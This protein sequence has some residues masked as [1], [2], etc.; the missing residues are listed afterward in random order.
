MPLKHRST[1]AVLTLAAALLASA[2]LLGACGGGDAAEGGSDVA[3]SQ[4]EPAANAASTTSSA[5]A[6]ADHEHGPG[7][8]THADE[9]A[10]S[11][12]SPEP[13]DTLA[14]AVALAPEGSATGSATLTAVAR[15]D[16]ATFS[17]T[18]EGMEP[19]A[20]YSPHLNQ[21]S[22]E[23]LGEDIAALTPV[24]T[25]S[26]G[27]GSSH[28]TVAL[29]SLSGHDHGAVALHGPDGDPVAC[30]ALHLDHAHAGSTG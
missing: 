16:S 20:T 29:S 1:R 10:A 13:G 19:E 12:S 15:G 7:T 28:A 5:G 14:H 8:H 17:V 11:A 4:G 23:E 25:G 26:S 18:V 24:A 21:G 22:C 9:G 2:A 30:G 3:S 27:S 6:E